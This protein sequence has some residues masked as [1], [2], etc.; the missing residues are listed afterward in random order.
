MIATGPGHYMVRRTT[1]VSQAQTTENGCLMRKQVE[2]NGI[3]VER[4]ET[5]R[6]RSARTTGDFLLAK[7]LRRRRLTATG[8]GFGQFNAG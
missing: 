4:S 2:P 1:N 3:V 5:L 6:A 7:P 8:A